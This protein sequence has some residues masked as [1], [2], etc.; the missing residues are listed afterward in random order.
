MA[1]LEEALP[2]ARVFISYC[3]VDRPDAQRLCEKLEHQ[4]LA[5]WIAPRDVR[6]GPE[7]EWPE[8]IAEAIANARAVVLVWSSAAAASNEVRREVRVAAEEARHLI[9]VRIEPAA[10]PRRFQYDLSGAHWI[11]A[12]GSRIDDTV[13]E[14]VRAVRAAERAPRRRRVRPARRVWLEGALALV[15]ALAASRG[16]L[17]RSGGAPWVTAQGSW[18]LSGVAA[19]LSAVLFHTARSATPESREARPG[20]LCALLFLAV[21]GA[22]LAGQVALV[23]AFEVPWLLSPREVENHFGVS[24]ASKLNEGWSAMEGTVWAERRQGE[25]HARI[26]VPPRS[27]WGQDA[28]KK[29]LAYAEDSYGRE[30]PDPVTALLSKDIM[31]IMHFLPQYEKD[32]SLLLGCLLYAGLHLVAVGALALASGGALRAAAEAS[33]ARPL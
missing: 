14:V 15:L 7:K 1:A 27:W 4:G 28:R 11:D 6:A 32:R 20:V 33:R 9:P 10:V 21:A 24:D 31:Q 22:A 16:L 8:A 19:A 18:L 25:F 2:E 17:G 29:I 12:F 5:C 13:A 3:S 23:R 30:F 26:L